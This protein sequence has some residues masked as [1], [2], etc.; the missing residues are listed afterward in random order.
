MSDI[1]AVKRSL[2]TSIISRLS[3]DHDNDHIFIVEWEWNGNRETYR[4]GYRE[5]IYLIYDIVEL[6]PRCW[7]YRHAASALLEA[8]KG[9]VDPVT[10]EYEGTKA[11]YVDIDRYYA[12]RGELLNLYTPVSK[13]IFQSITSLGPN[14]TQGLSQDKDESKRLANLLINKCWRTK[15]D[16]VNK[17]STDEARST[18]IKSLLDDPIKAMQCNSYVYSA[19][20]QYAI[21][22]VE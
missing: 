17:L 5:L 19:V 11:W 12:M 3:R 7:D 20:R 16:F 4:F 9:I 22:N 10:H 15:R 6:H 13:D 8:E 14:P 1:V 21:V 18:M 2:L